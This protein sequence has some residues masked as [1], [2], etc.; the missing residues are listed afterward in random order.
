MRAAVITVFGDPSALKEADVDTPSPGRGQVLVRVRAAGVNPIEAKVRAGAFGLPAPAVIGFEFA[1]VVEALGDGVVGVQPGD[2]VAGWPDSPA[3]GSYAEYT[4]SS[5]YTSIPDGVTF[6]Q[7]AAT[8]IG[9]D[10]AARGLS[11]LHL[12]AGETL[13]V[14]GASGALGSAAVQFARLAGVT[15]IGVAGPSSLPFVESLGA[16]AVEYGD[17]LVERVRAAAPQGIDAVLDTAGRGLLPAA[18]ELRGGNERV[19]TLADADAGRHGVP[20][21]YGNDSNRNSG[22]VHDALERIA[23]GEWVTRIGHT[24]PLAQASE[25]HRILETGHTSGKIILTP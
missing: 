6:E 23:A 24:L 1:G 21:S 3:Q 25:A 12:R 4:L 17:G 2:R 20:F 13:L 22:Y 5:N 11:E 14:T 9:A 10:N 15:V 8:V 7:A 19:V 16:T 18:I